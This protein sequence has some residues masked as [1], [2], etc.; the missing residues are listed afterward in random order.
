MLKDY[1]ASFA[2]DPAK[3]SA[4]TRGQSHHTNRYR[5][6]P[7]ENVMQGIDRARV[8]GV[9]SPFL[10]NF[11]DAVEELDIQY[12]EVREAKRNLFRWDSGR[13]PRGFNVDAEGFEALYCDDD[14]LT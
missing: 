10:R 3:V 5:D 13:I 1:L 4:Q 11:K 8:E 14:Q 7:R 2:R 9:Y 12:R 6:L